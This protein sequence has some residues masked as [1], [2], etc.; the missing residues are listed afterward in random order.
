M[1]IF[2]CGHLPTPRGPM[3]GI[4][5]GFFARDLSPSRVQSVAAGRAASGERRSAFFGPSVQTGSVAAICECWP[6]P[7]VQLVLLLSSL[8]VAEGLT[9][10]AALVSVVCRLVVVGERVFVVVLLAAVEG[11][12][13][14]SQLNASSALDGLCVSSSVA[15]QQKHT[16][17]G[18]GGRRTLSKYKEAQV[19][20]MP[21]SPSPFTCGL[22]AL[23]ASTAGPCLAV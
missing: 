13:S 12:T 9:L 6:D 14:I 20:T 23:F 17:E 8:R 10:N 15:A 5:P 22:L 7:P 16:I 4:V 11:T 18:G 2:Y 21:A 1:L 19:N 3:C